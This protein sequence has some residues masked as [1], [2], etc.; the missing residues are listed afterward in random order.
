MSR[1]TVRAP[2]SESAR[3]RQLAAPRAIRSGGKR[4]S[5]SPQWR[6]GSPRPASGA[7]P[8]RRA[9]SSTELRRERRAIQR[10]ASASR[11]SA[12]NAIPLLAGLVG[13][14]SAPTPAKWFRAGLE[15]TY[16]RRALRLVAPLKRRYDESGPVGLR[17]TADRPADSEKARMIETLER[18]RSEHEKLPFGPL[19]RAWRRSRTSSA[20]L[21]H[22]GA[23]ARPQADRSPKASRP[24]ERQSR[25][26]RGRPCELEGRHGAPLIPH[27]EP[28]TSRGRPD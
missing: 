1:T 5:R 24:P 17:T 27:L 23:N 20:S 8:P 9:R 16:R 28:K 3:A 14:R 7:S 10:S 2:S 26:S 13:V 4:R 12:L 25:S 6:R 19:E 11:A 18:R 22:E 21:K 15:G